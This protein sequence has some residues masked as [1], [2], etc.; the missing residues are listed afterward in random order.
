MHVPES[1]NLC[2]KMFRGMSRD[3][4]DQCYTFVTA[5]FSRVVYLCLHLHGI[6]PEVLDAS[7]SWGRD[8]NTG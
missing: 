2:R 3:S 1:F 6:L 5:I 7:F 8:T 4:L